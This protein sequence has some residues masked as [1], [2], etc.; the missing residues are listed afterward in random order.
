MSNNGAGV[1]K[2]AF[3]GFVAGFVAGAVTA[4]FLTTKTG[5]ELR[6]D[7]KRIAKDI[8]SKVEEKAS[9]VKNITKDKYNEI[10]NNVISSYKKIKDL[11]EKEIEFIKKIVAEQKDIAK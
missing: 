2:G 3:I 7:I 9:R 8:G 11:T 4:L 1:V 10:I 5:E 6:A